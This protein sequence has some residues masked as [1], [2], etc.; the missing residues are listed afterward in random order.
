VEGPAPVAKMPQRIYSCSDNI[1]GYHF[2]TIVRVCDTRWTSNYRAVTAIVNNLRAIVLTLQELHTESGDL[3]SEAGG[4]L[5]TFQ[6]GGKTVRSCL[7]LPRCYIRF[8]H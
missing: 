3:S 7:H 1:T 4:L 6:G 8:T 5:L 2:G